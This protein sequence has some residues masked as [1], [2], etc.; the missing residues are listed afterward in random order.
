MLKV[1][2][3]KDLKFVILKL[4]NFFKFL[5]LKVLK[6]KDLKLKDFL[7][8]KLTRFQLKYLKFITSVLTGIKFRVLELKYLQLKALKIKELKTTVFKYKGSNVRVLMFK[9]V[10]SKFMDLNLKF[11]YLKLKYTI[12]KFIKSK[13]MLVGL[14][15]RNSKFA[16]LMKLTKYKLKNLNLV[17]LMIHLK[18]KNKNNVSEAFRRNMNECEGMETANEKMKLKTSKRKYSEKQS[19]KLQLI[20]KNNHQKP[21][22]QRKHTEQFKI[23]ESKKSKIT[24]INNAKTKT[25]YIRKIYKENI[26]RKMILTKVGFKGKM[27]CV[28]LENQRDVIAI[29]STDD[30]LMKTLTKILKRFIKTKI[31][32]KNILPFKNKVTKPAYEFVNETKLFKTKHNVKNDMTGKMIESKTK[33]KNTNSSLKAQAKKTKTIIS[34]TKISFKT[35]EDIKTDSQQHSEEKINTKTPATKL[36]LLTILLAKIFLIYQ[37]NFT[38]RLNEESFAKLHKKINSN[39]TSLLKTLQTPASKRSLS[40]ILLFSTL[41]KIYSTF[42]ST[43]TLNT[44]KNIQRNGSISNLKSPAFFI[45]GFSIS[46]K[47]IVNPH[48]RANSVHNCLRVGRKRD[49]CSVYAHLNIFFP[50]SCTDLVTSQYNFNRFNLII[51]QLIY[52][53][54][55]NDLDFVVIPTM[56]RHLTTISLVNRLRFFLFVSEKICMEPVIL[57]FIAYA[58]FNFNKSVIA[59][60]FI[61]LRLNIFNLFFFVEKDITRRESILKFVF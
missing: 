56:Y 13:L 41:K 26:D 49:S 3:L 10:K 53:I 50:L 46:L 5:K 29:D 57:F 42:S 16:K 15:Y 27:T 37:T 28:R 2:K 59:M 14:K 6:I 4:K 23:I 45:R 48:G 31:F 8:L 34:T 52:S 19:S 25:A 35:K 44:L 51:K 18:L 58:N 24:V 40:N 54:I 17:D 38:S 7:K 11:I 9:G 32:T 43:K 39:V 47:Y 61:V 55:R 20:G 60:P 22:T 12:L 36:S 21:T 33:L 30:K 1:L